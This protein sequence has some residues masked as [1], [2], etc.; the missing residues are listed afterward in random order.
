MHAE[1]RPPS[2]FM[3]QQQLM[4]SRCLWRIF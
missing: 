3:Y 2:K 4:N 1:H